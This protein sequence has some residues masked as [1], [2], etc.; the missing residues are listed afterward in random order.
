MNREDS[1]NGLDLDN[2]C[3]LNDDVYSVSEFELDRFVR[4]RKRNLASNGQLALLELEAK[5]LLIGR[6]E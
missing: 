5:T 6:F 2:D 3:L 4:D 1:F